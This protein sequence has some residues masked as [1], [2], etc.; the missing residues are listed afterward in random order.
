[1]NE[2]P[3]HTFVPYDLALPASVW[4][5]ILIALAAAGAVFYFLR[6]SKERS[7]RNTRTLVAMLFFFMAMMA[8]GTGFFS[9]WN[10]RRTLAPVLIFEDRMESGYGTSQ[11]KNI[12]IAYLKTEDQNTLFPTPQNAKTDTFLLVEQRDG[13]THVFSHH[14][15]PVKEMAVKIRDLLEKN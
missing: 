6:P 8:A 5:S 15:Y 3:L 14:A 7:Q 10:S 11:L 12:K 2:T 4:L 13:R 9:F 1:M